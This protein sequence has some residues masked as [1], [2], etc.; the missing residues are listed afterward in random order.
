MGGSDTLIFF[1]YLSIPFSV[2][3]YFDLSFHMSGQFDV[4][5]NL[6]VDMMDSA[7]PSPLSV[8]IPCAS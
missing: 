4:D 6:L 3:V 1:T 5:E 8:M 2:N 7:P